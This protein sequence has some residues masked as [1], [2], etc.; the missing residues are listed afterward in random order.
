MHLRHFASLAVFYGP[1]ILVFRVEK[2]V[3]AKE[4]S[5][6]Y[7]FC[8]QFFSIMK[9]EKKEPCTLIR[10]DATKVLP[11]HLKVQLLLCEVLLPTSQHTER[12]GEC[13]TCTQGF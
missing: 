2:W 8:S 6:L 1:T 7:I 3:K 12:F 9:Q 5:G 11:T 4:T 10:G 13:L